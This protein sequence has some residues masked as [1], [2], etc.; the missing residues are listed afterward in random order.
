[1]KR[2]AKKIHNAGGHD[3]EDGYSKGYGAAIT[4]KTDR[5][6]P[7]DIKQKVEI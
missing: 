2:V 4:L 5:R 3:A 1:M 7:N 6:T